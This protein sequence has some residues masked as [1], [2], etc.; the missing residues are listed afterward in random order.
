MY[1]FEGF[2]TLFRRLAKAWTLAETNSGN[3][4]C[5]METP[6]PLNRWADSHK[7]MHIP[8]RCVCMQDCVDVCLTVTNTQQGSPRTLAG[9]L[10]SPLF[11]F[12]NK[13]ASV[14]LFIF[15]FSPHSHSC[16]HSSLAIPHLQD[17]HLWPLHNAPRGRAR[18][19]DY[20][21][22]RFGEEP[23]LRSIHEGTLPADGAGLQEP[24]EFLPVLTPPSPLGSISATEVSF[25]G[26]T[27][28]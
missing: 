1:V 6:G 8:S 25:M 16:F 15:I 21:V 13:N 14:L 26:R 23:A 28:P 10:R 4:P 27:V 9:E 2:G 3:T 7:D 20:D 11:V 12:R 22:W 17:D 5:S 18:L 24:V 19:V